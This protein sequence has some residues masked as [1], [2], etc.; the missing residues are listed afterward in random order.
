MVRRHIFKLPPRP[1][2][3]LSGEVRRLKDLNPTD[4]EAWMRQAYAS[5]RERHDG[6]TSRR[7]WTCHDTK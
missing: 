6:R 1:L 4:R 7:E 5:S 2:P 3:N